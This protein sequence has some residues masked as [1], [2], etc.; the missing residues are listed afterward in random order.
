MRLSERLSGAAIAGLLA[1]AMVT[2]WTAAPTLA[3]DIG[4]S[5]ASCDH[6]DKASADWVAC[7]A[8]MPAASGP[9]QVDAQLFYAGYWLAKN[10]RYAEA[11]AY[12]NKTRVKNSRVLTYIGF[13]TRKLGQ[14]D[15]AMNHYRAALA[16]D[17]ANMIARAYMGEGYLASGDLASARLELARIEKGCGT[18]CAAYR[19][20]AGAIEAHGVRAERKG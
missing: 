10:G 1:A 19:E 20:L 11:L 5:S 18:A 9:A 13:A 16:K 6:L 3:K 15:K 7:A 8:R 4:P 2:A 12:L 17:P 14:L